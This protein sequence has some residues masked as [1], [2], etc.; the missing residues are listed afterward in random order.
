MGETETEEDEQQED[1]EEEEEQEAG[2]VH[3]ASPL[4]IG[5]GAMPEINEVKALAQFR[6]LSLSTSQSDQE[7]EFLK[8]K[9]YTN[10]LYVLKH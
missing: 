4:R 2:P 6:L 10:I 9:Y 3:A 1:E 7:Q 8:S 5:G